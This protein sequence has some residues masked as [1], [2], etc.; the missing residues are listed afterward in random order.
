MGVSRSGKSTLL[1]ALTDRLGWRGLEADDLHSASNVSKMRR[2]I[3]LD[4]TDRHPWLAAIAAE[5]SR[6]KKGGVSGVVACSA[7]S[8]AA[9][10]R[11]RAADPDCL[12]VYLKAD[13]PLIE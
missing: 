10:E 7:L 12:F 4:D 9:R 1:N 3:P 6:W 2:G 5:M 13:L 11:F 8:R